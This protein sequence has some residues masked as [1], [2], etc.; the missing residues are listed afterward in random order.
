MAIRCFFGISVIGATADGWVRW[1]VIMVLL[2]NFT[3]G[4]ALK[5]AAS[6]PDFMFWINSNKKKTA[7]SSLEIYMTFNCEKS[8]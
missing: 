7:I 5:Y 1:G 8:N 4:Y 6:P 3:V 2:M